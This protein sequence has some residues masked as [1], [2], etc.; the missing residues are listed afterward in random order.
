MGW[1]Q[2]LYVLAARQAPNRT[3][4]DEHKFVQRGLGCRHQT[5]GT[6]PVGRFMVKG[7]V[8]GRCHDR[9]GW[10]GIMGRQMTTRLRMTQNMFS[11][12]KCPI[13]GG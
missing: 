3:N 4:D 9:V 1:L 7:R 11:S 12:A 10:C 8:G 6:L 13:S 5:K 2:A